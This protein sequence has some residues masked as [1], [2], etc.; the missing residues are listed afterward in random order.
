MDAVVQWLLKLLLSPLPPSLPV[1]DAAAAVAV[2]VAVVAVLVA[3]VMGVGVAGAGSGGGGVVAAGAGGAGEATVAAGDV[4]M[5]SFF[6]LA[7]VLRGVL[8]AL[9]RLAP[10][11]VEEVDEAGEME[12]SSLVRGLLP[13]LLLRE[14]VRRLEVSQSSS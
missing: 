3:G 2:V 1:A 8:P 7:G 4:A 13:R 11:D 5:A 6:R 9:P 14:F 10:R 12:R